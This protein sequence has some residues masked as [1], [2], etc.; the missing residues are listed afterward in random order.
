MMRYSVA[1]EPGKGDSAHG[2]VVPD[3]PGC[4]SAGDTFDEAMTAAEEAAAAWIDAAL[5]AGEVVPG[6]TALD[7]LRANP[8]YLG[9][10]FG[11]ITVDPAPASGS[12]RGVGSSDQPFRKV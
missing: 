12:A 10:S 6:P 2:V 9:W 4:F 1:I 3:L 7:A 8:E 11:V 5:D